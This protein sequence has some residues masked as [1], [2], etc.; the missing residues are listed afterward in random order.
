MR[1][2]DMSRNELTSVAVRSKLGPKDH[3]LAKTRFLAEKKITLTLKVRMMAKQKTAETTFA[4][5]Q[6]NKSVKCFSNEK[7]S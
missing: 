5:H 7:Y 6:Q 3:I 2:A 4:V 1:R